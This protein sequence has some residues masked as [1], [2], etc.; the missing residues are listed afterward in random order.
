MN[1]DNLIDNLYKF[2]DDSQAIEMKVYMKNQFEFLGIRSPL[3]NKICGNYFKEAK[4]HKIVDW[5]FVNKCW[6]LPYREFQYTAAYYLKNMQDFLD[7]KDVIKIKKLILEKSWWDTID[8]LDKVV[9]HI[10]FKY[11]EV[12]STIIDWSKSDN[13]WLRRVAIDHQLLRKDKTNKE[14]LE[15]ILVNNF[16]TDEFF[17]NKAIGWA[18]RDYSKVN[19]VWVRNFLNKYESDMANLSIREA[20]KYL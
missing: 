9:G 16:G 7:D 11:P 12:V 2:R 6:N 1:L 13:I 4:K 14:L 19:P 20:S 10:S 8:I 15:Q 3:R 17:I 18:L 5:D